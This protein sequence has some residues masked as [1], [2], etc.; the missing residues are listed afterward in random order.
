MYFVP[1]TLPIQTKT[2]IVTPKVNTNYILTF[3]MWSSIVDG[4]ERAILTS[5]IPPQLSLSV[6]SKGRPVRGGDTSPAS[7][8]RLPGPDDNKSLL[9]QLHR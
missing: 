6:Q 9:R 3:N 8:L 7:R 5:H 4:I 2:D 1:C